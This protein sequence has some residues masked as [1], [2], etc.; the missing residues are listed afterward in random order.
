MKLFPTL[1][2]LIIGSSSLFAQPQ[3]PLVHQLPPVVAEEVISMNTN[4]LVFPPVEKSKK[5][6]PILIFVY[7]FFNRHYNLL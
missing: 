3:H 1:F 2:V 7:L 4:Y 5:K 6:V